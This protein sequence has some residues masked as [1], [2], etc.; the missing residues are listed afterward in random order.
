[1]CTTCGCDTDGEIKLLIPGE[2]HHD[3]PHLNHDHHH[4]HDHNHLNGHEHPHH[5]HESKK[6]T[7]EQDI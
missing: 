4:V 3:H 2:S 6:I 1:M 7:L 5:L